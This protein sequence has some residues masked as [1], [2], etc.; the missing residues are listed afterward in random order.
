MQKSYMAKKDIQKQWFLIN[1]DNQPMGRLAVTIAEILM[2]KHRP[3]YTPHIDTGDFVVVTNVDKIKVGGN[4]MDKKH[5]YR[6][7]GYPGGLRK[8]TTREMQEKHPG[9]IL[10]LAVRRM[11]PKTRMGR[12]MIKKLKI[13]TGV[14]HPHTAQQPQ[15]WTADNKANL[16][17]LIMK[18]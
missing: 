18:G 4:K 9:K 3:W 6:Y 11:L 7:S 16:Q 15:E 1:A 5:Y 17:D 12:K 10:F 2:G 8:S 13:Y 14:D